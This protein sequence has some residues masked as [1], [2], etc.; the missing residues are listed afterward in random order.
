MGDWLLN[1]AK[2][3]HLTVASLDVLKVSFNPEQLNI[4][5]LTLN[6]KDLQTIIEKE[7]S[8]NGFDKSFIKEAVIDFKFPELHTN[9]TTFY[10]F[11]YLV[12]TDGKRY[13]TGRIIEE[14]L[15]PEFDPF[16]DLNINPT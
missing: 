10:C 6:A 11:P 9:K 8:E 1:A 15:E 13:E 7:L 3:L 5:P 4:R 2:R 14:G 12:D 16:D